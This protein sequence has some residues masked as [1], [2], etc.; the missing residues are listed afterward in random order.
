[1]NSEAVLSGDNIWP[2]L[3]QRASISPDKVFIT[4]ANSGQQFTYR[5]FVEQV[6]LLAR[7]LHGLGIGSESVVVWQFPSRLLAVLMSYALSRLNAVQAPVIHLYR[8]R[9]LEAILSQA[10]ATHALVLGGENNGHYQSMM[11]QSINNAELGP[12]APKLVVVAEDWQNHIA[13]EHLPRY[14]GDPH[15]VSWYFFTSGTTSKPKGA[16]HT[17][18]TLLAGARHMGKQVDVNGTDVGSLAFPYAHIGGIIYCSIMVIW[19]MSVVMLDGFQGEWAASVFKRYGVTLGGGSTAHYQ[20]LLAEQNKHPGEPI[21]PS[22]RILSGGGAAKPAAIFD[23]VKTSLGAIIIH[24]YGMTE[25]PMSAYNSLHDSDEQLANT[26]GILLPGLEGL[27]VDSQGRAVPPGESGEL[28]L[29][30]P[31]VCKGYLDDAHTRDGFTEEGFLHT[32]DLAKIRNDGHLCVTGR[33]KDVIIRKGENISAQEIEELL[34]THPKV[35]DVA[36][37]GLPDEERGELVCAVVELHG[38]DLLT[39]EEMAVFLSQKKLMRQKI[40]E[41]LELIDKLPRDEILNKVKKSELRKLF[42]A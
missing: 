20:I 6:D 8:E 31:N 37:I 3:E 2:L 38:E 36:V 15:R 13:E 33:I 24:G 10:K 39:M 30:G 25:A 19:G 22:L 41:R 21:I 26:D 18:A 23:Q 42:L 29:R 16:R 40:P 11:Q 1:M 7:Y 4:E 9:E 28:L 5:Q 12:G 14:R 17:D 32:G 35:N 34:S 27:V